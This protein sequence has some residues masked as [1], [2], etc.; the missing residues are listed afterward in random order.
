MAMEYSS[1]R[2][3]TLTLAHRA[4]GDIRRG[5]F[6]QL[7]N[8]VDM[9]AALAKK[10]QQKDF[11]ACAQ[12]ALQRTDSCYYS[13][14]HNLLDSVDDDR[15][16]T[17]GV[18]LGFGGLIY[19]ASKMKVQADTDRK[20]FSWVQIAQCGDAALADLVPA[21]AKQGSYVWVLDATRGNPADAAALALANPESVFGILAEPETLTASCIKALLPCMNI[22]VLPLLHTPEL[23][24]EACLAA[25]ALKKHR[26]MYMLTVQAGEDEIDSILQPVWVESIAQESLFCMISRRGDVTPETSKQLRSGIVAG[27]LETGLPVLMLDWEGD[28]AYLNRHISE[29]AV[30]GKHLPEGYTFPLGTRF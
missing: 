17:V 23:T 11:F 15:I 1:T 13:M 28:I 5:G 27:R 25:R 3:F 8:Y 18:N 30:L 7:R 24:P 2:S 4:V 12:A 22:V 21:A 29:Y 10:P 6:R 16:C 20:P 26:M 14:I 9:C 19:G